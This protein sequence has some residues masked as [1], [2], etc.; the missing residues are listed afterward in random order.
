M[1]LLVHFFNRNVQRV[2]WKAERKLNRETFGVVAPMR[3]NNGYRQ[4]NRFGGYRGYQHN[5]RSRSGQ[6]ANH[7]GG[8]GFN[9]ANKP[10]QQNGVPSS[11]STSVPSTSTAVAVSSSSL[12]SVSPAK[13]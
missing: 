8:S 5:Y 13:N 1:I 6:R 4:N 7:S 3:R 10:Q 12:V 9:T 11:N 2:D